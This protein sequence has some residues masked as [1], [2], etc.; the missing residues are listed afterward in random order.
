MGWEPRTS[1]CCV[2]HHHHHHHRC[3][4]RCWRRRR[5]CRAQ[6]P[7]NAHE[8][9]RT[10]RMCVCVCAIRAPISIHRLFVFAYENI[11]HYV[12][13]FCVSLPCLKQRV[14]N[15]QPL[16]VGRCPRAHIL[17][18]PCGSAWLMALFFI[19]WTQKGYHHRIWGST[20]RIGMAQLPAKCSWL[21]DTWPEM[22]N[23]YAIRWKNVLRSDH[24]LCFCD[25]PWAI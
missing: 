22:P 23:A 3:W 16:F 9:L 25:W 11:F 1:F 24:H 5:L 10:E 6:A 17:R 15:T 14:A 12:K 20:S 21:W 7:H 2:A 18:I 19:E 8:S 13:T 4:R